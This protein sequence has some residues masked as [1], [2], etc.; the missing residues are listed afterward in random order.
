MLAIAADRPAHPAVTTRSGST[1]YRELADGALR[2]AAALTV[3]GLGLGDRIAILAR[4]DLPYVE[5]IYGADFVGAVVVGINCRLS[6]AEVADI[7]DDCQPSL[8]F[9]ADEYLPLLG[10]AA[11]GVL[12]V[13][14]DRDY[15]TWCG[16]GDMTRFVPRVGYADSVVLMVYTSGTTGRSKGVRLTEANITAALAANRDVWFVG[17]EIR[18]LALFPLFNI[19][20][21]I[22]LLSI[23]HVGGE[24][25]IAENASG[26]TILELLGARRITHA[27]FVAAMIVALLD[28]PADDEIDL[29]SLRVLIYGAAPSSAAVIDR[30]MRRLPT[31]DFFQGYGMTET[32]GGIAMTPPHRYGEEIAPASVGR[33]IPSYEIRIVDPVRRTD[34]PVGVEGEIWARGPQNTIGYWNRAE[35]TDR[36][37]AADGWLR[38]GDVGVLDAA[39]NLYVVDR[40]KDMIISG[41]FN[42]YSLEVEQILVGHPD[43]GD[44]AVF[45]VPDERWGETVVA[46]VTLR[47]GATCVPAD[48][49]EFARARLAHFKC[50]RRIEIL[51]E[52]P[53]N[54]AGKILKR[55]LRGRFS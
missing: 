5:L 19:S 52:L 6:P 26:A 36:L 7:L 17:P 9:V 24:V 25:V 27:L 54:A 46:V 48:L 3:Q 43:V 16:T 37:L 4:N 55:E 13:S 28:Q 32:C 45:G 53:R 29:S 44:A 10:S 35:E 22:F 47:P 50:P 39:H 31:C 23:L 30:A 2:V 11:A 42:V 14:L 12:R 51:D 15:R 33:A 8:V 1:S 34:L 40:L 49:S 38:T 21:S 18:A 41:G 20:G